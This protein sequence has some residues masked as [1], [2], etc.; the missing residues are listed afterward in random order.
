MNPLVQPHASDSEAN[1]SSKI[2]PTIEFE[3][4]FGVED[5]KSIETGKV[6]QAD[7]EEGAFLTWEDLWVTVSNG[8]NGR[9]PILQGLNGY[10]KPGKL[11][12]IMGPSGCGKSTLLDA[13]AG[14][15]GSKR[16][17]TGKILI[18]GRKQALAYGTS[19]Y[20]TEDDTILTT[21][22]VGEAIN[23][24]AHLQLPDSMSKSEKKERADFTIR[25]MGL[26][27]AINTRIGGRGSKGLSGGQ[28]R[29]V[30][31]CIEI[32]THP[33]LLF[34]DEPTSGLDSAA[35][36]YVMRRIS[37][38]NKKDGMPMTIIASIHQPSNEIFQIFHNLCLLSS[39]KTVYFGPVSSANK[40]F[41]S[42]GFPCPSLQSPSDHFLKTI[43]KDFELDPEKELAGGLSTEEAIH[44]LVKS[45][46][47][48][49]F[50][51]QVLKEVAQIRKRDSYTMEKKHHADFVTQCLIL[52]RR[53][54]VN[55]YREV[56]Y[57]WLRLLIYGALALSL[58]TMFFDIGSSSES[59]QARGSLLVF[60][61]TFLTF[62]NVAGFPSFVED[63]KVFERERLNGH[64]GVTAFTIGNTLSAIPFLL[65]MSLIP[66]A[67]VYY[68]VGLQKGHEHFLYFISVLFISLLLVEGLMMIIA[69]MIPNFLMGIIFGSG[70]LG[71]MMLDGG[72]YRLPSD[73]PKPFWKYPLRYISFHKYAYQGLFKNEFQGLTFTGNQIGGPMTISG[74]DIL[75]HVWQVEMNYSKWVDVAMLV[76]MA[77]IYR[78][79]FLVIIK[80]IEKVKPL[81]QQ[82]I[83]PKQTV[84]SLQRQGAIRLI[85]L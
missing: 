76:G 71:V 20:V 64:Y 13:L 5:I 74:E 3:T 9:K 11:L 49:E 84:G 12:A 66:G 35:S 79:L 8:K 78:I 19:A 77:L 85:S 34:L 27:D 82:L 56:G 1:N 80:S 37:S 31:I 26:Q 17:Q 21:L 33:R 4:T 40:F 23:Y 63:M 42:N 62:I 7:Q 60:V 50:S 68:L 67:L 16:N 48:S 39:G 36:Y 47:S 22:T 25:E 61:V 14:R 18:N 29:R 10:A 43:N 55:M 30:S 75:R 51:H 44:I 65:L 32:L 6:G 41:S 73:I 70:I 53:S 38:L 59:I 46:D 57:Y 58:G 69:S 28:K 2:L 81:L 52:T 15:L 72:F 83:V 45:Y 24:S 54:F